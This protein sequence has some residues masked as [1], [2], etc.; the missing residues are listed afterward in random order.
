MVVAHPVPLAS[1]SQEESEALVRALCVL[2]VPV[3]LAGNDGPRRYPVIID[4]PMPNMQKK[5]DPFV[6]KQPSLLL[7]VCLTCGP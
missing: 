7:P 5:N 4:M 2:R 1:Q 3:G 6:W